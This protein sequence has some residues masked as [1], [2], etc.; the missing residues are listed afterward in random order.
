MATLREKI[1][2]IIAGKKKGLETSISGVADA[3]TIIGGKGQRKISAAEAIRMYS[4]W[5]YA[6][7]RAIAEEIGRAR[8]RLYKINKNG[9]TEE[10]L[11]HELLDILE[12]VNPIQSGYELRF[13]TAAHL[14]LTGD[15]YWFLEGVASDTDK[16][17]GIYI[18]RPD[19]IKIIKKPIPELV[20]GYIFREG[21]T[22]RTF[23]PHEVIH[24]SYPDPAD[25]WNGKG[26]VDAI[27]DWISADQSA[28]EVNLKYFENGARLSGILKSKRNLTDAQMKVLKRDFLDIYGGKENQYQV[29]VLPIDT[30]YEEQSA[31]P[32]DMDFAQL[33]QVMRDKILAGFRVPKTVL[34]ASESETNRATAETANYVFAARTILPKLELI[35][36]QLNERLVPRYGENL[37]L[38]F[39]NPVPEDRTAKM[40]EIKAILGAAPAASVNEVRRIYLDL[41]P[42]QNGD[43]VMTNLSSIPLGVPENKP[44]PKKELRTKTRKTSAARTAAK[45][46]EMAD[47]ITEKIAR[48]L[49]ANKKKIVKALR[50]ARRD[51]STVTEEQWEAIHKN[52][53]ARVTRYENELVKAV[54]EVNDKQEKEIKAKLQ[55]LTKGKRKKAIT[56]EDEWIS[57]LADL[58]TP[59]ISRL[60]EEE[61]E[62]ALKLLGTTG[63]RITQERRKAIRRSVERMAQS[64]ED[65]TIE[66]IEQIIEEGVKQGLHYSEIGEQIAS[67]YEISNESRAQT[68]ARTETFRT[69]N[70]ANK[71]AWKQ[72][73]TV[74]TIKWYTAADERVCE[75]CGPMHGKTIDIEK[76][77][78]D[79]GDTVPGAEG[80]AL[81]VDYAPVEAG[82]LHPNCRCFTR[83]DTIELQED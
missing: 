75:Y 5:T 9:D 59:I 2:E 71:E 49:I 27:A 8:F 48:A 69:A 57:L 39:D 28:T 12:A 41:P 19:K 22:E 10:I 81:K 79:V 78:F 73:G 17:K 67:L 58:S 25:E 70:E 56:D 38:T 32:K 46:K 43:A 36:T 6:A 23:K 18:L 34:G 55:E 74:R 20:G 15:A 52:F 65:T 82:T 66:A 16:P 29:A 42:I 13:K 3:L 26:T 7:V 50:T 4:G 80:G 63:F 64:Y 68:I 51:I 37:W 1:A 61:G 62:E 11:E 54:R 35:A 44:V 24:L 40:E 47:E 83:P 76:N 60:Y 53:V 77:F 31:T 45:R 21:A 30:E 14:E 33:Q 72:T